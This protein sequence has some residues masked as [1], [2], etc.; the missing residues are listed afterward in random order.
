MLLLVTAKRF[1]EVMFTDKK[2]SQL[3]TP[4]FKVTFFLNLIIIDVLHIWYNSS[5][6]YVIR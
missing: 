5:K 1:Q 4:H 6:T 2:N 3:K